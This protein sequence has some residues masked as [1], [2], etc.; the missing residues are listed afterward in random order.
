MDGP[1]GFEFSREVDCTQDAN[2][3][4]CCPADT[5]EW[6]GLDKNTGTGKGGAADCVV[7]WRHETCSSPGSREGK[8]GH[9]VACDPNNV[10]TYIPADAAYDICD[11]V[12]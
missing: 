7:K 12:G 9:V 11:D 4:W 3:H 8:H 5:C 2:G 1:H 6:R 10:D